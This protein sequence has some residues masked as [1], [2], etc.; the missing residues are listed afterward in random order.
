MKVEDALRLADVTAIGRLLQADR[1]HASA[2]V[3]GLPPLLALLRRSTGAP[4]NVSSCA[5]MLL[6]AGADPNSHTIEWAG[7]GKRSALFDAVERADLELVQLLLDGEQHPTRT[8]SNTRASSPTRRSLTR[9]TRLAS[10]TWSTTSWTSKTPTAC[11]GS[12]NAASTSTPTAA[13]TTR[14]VAA[15]G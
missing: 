8:P 6:E 14:S 3:Q 7:E 12:S 9:S 1:R 2:E 11:A 5:R 4:E 15:A 13:C 10:R